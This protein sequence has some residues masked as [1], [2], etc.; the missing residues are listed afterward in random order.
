MK[1]VA[2]YPGT[3]DPVTYGHIDIIKRSLKIFERVIVAVAP[4]PQKAPLFDINERVSMIQE[5]TR[6]LKNLQVE[7]FDG[8]L[9]DYVKREGGIAIIRGL[10]AVSDF[11]YE[12]QIALMNRKLDAEVETVFMMPNQEFTY[13]TSS[14]VKAVAS[15]GGQVKDFVPEI[16][17]KKLR[18]KL[19]SPKP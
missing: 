14:I 10:R 13:L 7:G 12:L 19:W 6:D 4:N 15:Y 3:F 17:S 9:V 16:V 1:K 2:V 18:E 5:A 11:E 8:L